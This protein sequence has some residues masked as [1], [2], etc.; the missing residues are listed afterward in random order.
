MLQA[1]SVLVVEDHG[2]TRSLLARLL[3]TIGFETVYEAACGPQA[4]D[5]MWQHRIDLV[6]SDFHMDDFDGLELHARM[7]E[8]E[9]FHDIPF[10]LVSADDDLKLINQVAAAGVDML[11]KPFPGERLLDIVERAMGR[12]ESA[13]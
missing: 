4:L 13:A 2:K 6:V 10:V 12:F 9:N 7:R 11:I 8:S 5:I 1:R 3:Q